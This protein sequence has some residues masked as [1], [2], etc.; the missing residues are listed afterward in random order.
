MSRQERIFDKNEVMKGLAI[1]IALFSFSASVLIGQTNGGLSFTI[2]YF[3][4][5]VYF[6]GD[7]I[8][9]ESTIGNN[10]SLP[11]RLE[12][13]SRRVFNLDFVVRSIT[14]IQLS[15]SRRFT[16]DRTANEPVFFRT[17]EL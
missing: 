7:Q 8:M 9:I 12:I 1:S 11:I 17:I 2:R 5:D 4:K 10:S 13:A 14:N 6:L 15:H 16:I 3:D